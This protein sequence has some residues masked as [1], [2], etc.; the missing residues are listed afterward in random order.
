MLVLKS[1]SPFT[2]WVPVQLGTTVLNQA[3]AKIMV[4]ELTHVSSMWHQTYMSI[5]VTA[6]AAR[7]IEQGCQKTPLIDTPLVTTK[8]IVTPL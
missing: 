4:E 5:M 7:T 1:F 2:S 3:M 6:C 8:S